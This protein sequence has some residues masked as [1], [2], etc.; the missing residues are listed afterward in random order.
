MHR[1]RY[2]WPIRPLYDIPLEKIE[3]TRVCVCILSLAAAVMGQ[4]EKTLKTVAEKSDYKATSRYDDVVTFIDQLAKQ[5]TAVR[6][7]DMGTSADG[8]SIPLLIL[9][10]PPIETPEEAADSGKLVVMAFGNIHAGEVCGKEALLMLARD[11][12]DGPD[13]DLLK[14]LVIIFAPIFN[15]DGNEHMS[16]DNRPGQRGPADGMGQ[17]R[18]AQDLDL[19]RDYIKLE[20]PEAR[21]MVHFYN[22]WDPSVIIDTHTTNGSYHGYT[23]TYAAPKNPAGDEEIIEY[24]RDTMLPLVGS[25]MRKETGYKSFYYGNFDRE[26]S[27]WSTYPARPRFGTPYRGLRNRLAILSE[28]YAYASYRDRILATRAFVRQCLIYASQ[29][30]DDI[31]DMV[32]AADERTTDVGNDP[33]GGDVVAI[34]SE[35]APFAD[36]V[37]IEGFVED[38][39]D[40]RTISTGKPRTYEVTHFGQFEPTLSVRRPYAYLFPP[41]METIVR[42]LQEHGIEVEELREDIELPIESYV[43][44]RVSHADRPFQK[45]RQ[46]T[47]DVTARPET[48]RFMA[49]Q[50]VV[51]TGQPLGTLAV[52]LLEP[53]SDDGLCTWNFFDN[54]IEEG[55]EFP[56]VRLV[57]A[58]PVT[59]CRVRP[60]PRDAQPPKPITFEAM[61]DSDDPPD[62]T[63]P[64]VSRLT[65]LDDGEHYLQVKD[66]VLWRIEAA[67]GRM[68]RFHSPDVMAAA[69]AALPTI[70]DET[71]DELAGRSRFRM[72]KNRTAALFQH[73]ND[74]YYCR[75]D[76]KRAVRLTHTPGREETPTFSPDG[77]FVSFVR[78][79]NL[80]VVDVAT[81]TERALTTDGGEHIR[82]GK[83]TWVYYEELNGRRWKAYWW[84]P[85]S[86]AIAFL[87]TDDSPIKPFTVIDELP[88][89]QDVERTAYPKA[90]DPNPHVTIGMVSAAGGSVRWADLSGYGDGEVLISRVGWWP[91]S[92][93]IFFYAQDRAQTWLDVNTAS[94]SDGSTSRLLRDT[95][96]AWVSD[97]GDPEFLDDGSFLL[98]SERSGWRHLYRF[99]DDGTLL[100]QL[101][102]GEWEVRKVE[103][104]DEDAGW[105]YFS[106]TRDSHIAENL[107]RVK[108]SGGEPEQLTS[109][110]GHHISR[111]SPNGKYYIDRFSSH[112]TPVRVHLYTADGAPVRTIDSN[113]VHVLEEYRFGDYEL[114]QIKTADGFTLEASLMMPPDFD[115]NLKYPV[116]FMT[117]GGPHAPTVRDSW[118]KRRDRER[119][120]AEAGFLVFR[121]DPRSASGK[122]A[123]SAWTAYKRFGEGELAD[124]TEAIEWLKKKPYVDG[125]RI[126]MSGHSY[127]GFMT[128]YAMTHSDLFAA[129]IAGAP[130]TDWHNY[131]TIYTERYMDTPQENPDG[132]ETTSVVGAAADLHGRLLILHGVMDDNVHMQNT[133]QFVNALQKADKQFELMF[134]PKSRH[135]IRGK[136]YNRLIVDF[137][138]RTLSKPTE[139]IEPTAV[140]VN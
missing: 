55:K 48:R 130:V 35:I 22:L 99:D 41:S 75:F 47:V 8:R 45:H 31:R 125:D 28:A 111:V 11:I 21:A 1:A 89:H 136:H 68:E 62:F 118:S 60:L 6:R 61:Y 119:V 16:K 37:R 87:R 76:G 122:G 86:S 4:G 78:D 98:A 115:P 107:Y 9:A 51:R 19:N 49:G 83:F 58:L 36:N 46:L 56:V 81:Q 57:D 106:G 27:R 108:I 52:Y 77:A 131:D 138:T 65:W 92:D 137:I 43:I 32:Q 69:L 95:T 104:V 15:V 17:R 12:A 63:G 23:I 134:Y 39:R 7:S 40:G 94:R 44:D 97:P 59:R 82:N 3:M 109:S 18:N 117:Y 91:D 30:A 74:L 132:Y 116:W 20:S 120:L 128:A 113:P 123:Q 79:D 10:D 112:E 29:R 73:E 101:T 14:D 13:H 96:Q 42:K 135:G 25:R 70:D 139:T 88:V 50:I 133:L 5:S 53:Q 64:P 140:G 127:G 102:S 114:L 71:A 105:V 54:M 26:H 38:V 110:P 100:K 2:N 126:G 90:G 85:D 80:Y 72:N 67:S 84:S 66:D 33:S 103:H 124:I 121:C 34:R 129:G 93:K 24:V